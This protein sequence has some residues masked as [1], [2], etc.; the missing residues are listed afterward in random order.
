[1]TPPK[2]DGANDD[3][4]GDADFIPPEDNETEEDGNDAKE[5]NNDHVKHISLGIFVCH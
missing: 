4:E 1:M 5:D 3:T 2:I